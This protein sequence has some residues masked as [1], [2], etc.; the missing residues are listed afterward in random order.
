MTEKTEKA[1]E[2]SMSNTKQEILK[3]Y[4]ELQKS[5]KQQKEAELKPENKAAEK[6]VAEVVAVAD[7]VK[8]IVFLG[9]R[10][11]ETTR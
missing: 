8:G 1:Q 7:S 5:L 6:K 11:E 10:T 9:V 3:A 2:V 4:N